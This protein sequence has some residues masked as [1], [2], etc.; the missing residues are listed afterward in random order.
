MHEVA[1]QAD[2][3]LAVSIQEARSR[4][5]LDVLAAGLEQVAAGLVPAADVLELLHPVDELAALVLEDR[6]ALGQRRGLPVH[7]LDVGAQILALGVGGGGAI[8]DLA[9]GLLEALALP[10]VAGER[11]LEG[12]ELRAAA[13]G[14]LG[15]VPA[16]VLDLSAVRVGLA[17]G[18]LGLV[19]LP[20]AQLELGDDAA[21]LGLETR[22]LLVDGGEAGGAGRLRREVLPRRRLPV[23]RV[24]VGVFGDGP[25]RGGRARGLLGH[26]EVSRRDRAVVGRLQDV[27]VEGVQTLPRLGAG[28]QPFVPAALPPLLLAAQRAEPR[29][30]EL[31]GQVLGLDRELFVPLGHLRLLLER[32]EL[33]AELGQHV[34]QPQEILVQPRQLALGPLLA[35]TVLGDAG[36]LLDVPAPVLRAGLQ[37]LLE[38]PLAD[39]RVQRATDAG[40]AQQLLDVEEAHDLAADPVL[41]LP[42][43][44]DRP[45]HLDLRHGHGDHAGRVVDHELHL[46]HAE[47]GAGRR[48]GEDHVGHLAAAERAGPLF[49]EHPADRVHEVRLAGSVR[50]HDHG[51]AGGELENGLVRERLEAADRERA[52][53]HPGAMLAAAVRG[54][55]RLGPESGSAD[56]PEP[57][58]A[59]QG[60]GDHLDPLDVRAT[61]AVPAPGDERVDVGIEPLERGLHAAVARIAD[62][63]GDLAPARLLRARGP[64]EHALHPAGDGHA[65]PLHAII[66]PLVS[67]GLVGGRIPWPCARIRRPHRADRGR[68]AE[69]LRRSSRFPVRPRR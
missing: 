51:D 6:P 4:R 66:M 61:R 64:E 59:G 22:E 13:G 58:L 12:L 18:G 1:Q 46:G 34:L 65:R 17:E 48:S 63:A 43:A 45:A 69:R 47:G 16:H 60:L 57:V 56:D 50:T 52:K 33:A 68:R 26:R 55:G 19:E 3:L 23:D 36:G 28:G 35:A 32:L 14:L 7:L 2:R 21:G 29:G 67:N 10:L 49:T 40:L 38:L 27:G 54:T 11:A 41:A 31:A 30:G 15:Q 25:R 62:P 5:L 42:R 20:L 9:Q 8:V 37:D 44:E 24:A 53:E 39:D